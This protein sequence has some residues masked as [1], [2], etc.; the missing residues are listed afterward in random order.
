MKVC[1]SLLALVLLHEATCTHLETCNCHEIQDLV[2]KTVEQQVQEIKTIVNTTV[3]EAVARLEYKLSHKI[4]TA[5]SRIN[6][7]NGIELSDLENNLKSTMKRLLKPIQTQ[8]DY[9]L[10][11]PQ[12]NSEDNPAESCKAIYDMYTNAPSGHYWIKTSSSPVRVY[13]KMNATCENLKGGWMR[14]AY[15]DMRN[16]SHQCPSGF[17]LTTRS[18]NPRRVCDITSYPGCMYVWANSFSTVLSNEKC[19]FSMTSNSQ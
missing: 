15:L 4:N 11:P 6:T 14:V 9:H 2:N 3:E 19:M 16:S 13:C 7:T 1:L 10:P 5:I 12:P 8:L 17:N 18:S